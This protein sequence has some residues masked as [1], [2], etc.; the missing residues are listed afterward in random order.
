MLNEVEH[1]PS[2][3]YP[4][5]FS[6]LGRSLWIKEFELAFRLSPAS[7][8]RSNLMSSQR[9]MQKSTQGGG[10]KLR[11][12]SPVSFYYS[13]Y[14]IFSK[15]LISMPQPT[16]SQ[17]SLM[18]YLEPPKMSISDIYIYQKS[19]EPRDVC[20]CYQRHFGWRWI[21]WAV[22]CV[23][24]HCSFRLEPSGHFLSFFQN[25]RIACGAI[26]GE[27]S[28]FISPFRDCFQRNCIEDTSETAPVFDSL[29]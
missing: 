4:L 29:W 12:L 19:S 3:W 14:A 16:Q 20:I 5:P 18:V 22:N 6:E 24:L 13:L 21:F 26:I 27:G 1:Q 9:I 8:N 28:W 2:S 23:K 25:S 10:A 15:L 7:L 17:V 11:G